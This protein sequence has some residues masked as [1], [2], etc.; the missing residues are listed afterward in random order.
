M[1]CLYKFLKDILSVITDQFKRISSSH[2]LL[3]VSCVV[4]QSMTLNLYQI[5]DRV[6]VACESK[7]FVAATS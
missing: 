3:T 7:L 6:T 2:L 5:S 1:F 4:S